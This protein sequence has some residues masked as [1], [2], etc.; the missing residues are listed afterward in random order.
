MTE[1][2]SLNASFAVHSFN[3]IKKMKKKSLQI[4]GMAQR[5]VQNTCFL[6]T[7][8]IRDSGE[9]KTFTSRMQCSD[10]IWIM[11]FFFSYNLSLIFINEQVSL[12]IDLTLLNSAIL[13]FTYFS[14]RVLRAYMVCYLKGRRCSF[15]IHDHCPAL[16]QHSQRRTLVCILPFVPLQRTQFQATL[17]N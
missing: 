13:I 6:N 10:Y 16:S 3:K 5:L 8:R 12:T 4:F 9:T 11:R 15:L 1:E 2:A 17:P 14:V 7:L